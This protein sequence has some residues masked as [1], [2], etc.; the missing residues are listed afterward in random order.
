MK[1][2]IMQ[3]YFLPYIGYF[4]LINLADE[5]VIYDNIEY[6]K[7]GWINRN[8]ILV[9]GKDV[10]I[11]LPLKKDSDYKDIK[12]RFIADNWHKE[13]GKMLNKIK[14]AYRKSSCFDSVYPVIEKCI[15]SEEKNLFGF[16]FKSL[17]VVCEYLE[18]TTPFVISSAVPINHGLKSEKKVLALCKNRNADTYINPIGG[19]KLYSKSNF[20][21]E[22]INLQFLKT[23]G[24]T[25]KQFEN[26]FV[27]SLSILDVMMFNKKEIIKSFLN[28]SFTLL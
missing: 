8:R 20:E 3:P 10:F 5:F 12:D 23:S 24:I 16:I 11:T 14:E 4:Q 27:P 25:Y 28:N 18:I 15:L 26:S 2:A 22:K 21:N 13:R 1:L 6:S 9:N 7:D 19:L 17:Q